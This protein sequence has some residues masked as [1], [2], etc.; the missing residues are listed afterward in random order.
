MFLNECYFHNAI[1]IQDNLVIFLLV[2]PSLQCKYCIQCMLKRRCFLLFTLLVY[3]CGIFF[4]FTILLRKLQ[5]FQ[6]SFLKGRPVLSILELTPF[7]E[8]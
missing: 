6:L 2:V 7:I 3:S 8:C 1:V 5:L 4:T